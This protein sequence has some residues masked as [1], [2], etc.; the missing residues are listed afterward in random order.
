MKKMHRMLAVRAA[1]LGRWLQTRAD[2]RPLGEAEQPAAENI[3]QL[4]AALTRRFALR[5][6]GDGRGY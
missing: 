1:H 2:C 6:S 5:H 4:H 3:I